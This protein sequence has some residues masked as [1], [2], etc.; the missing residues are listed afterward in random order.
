MGVQQNRAL[1]GEAVVRPLVHRLGI[2]LSR[3][4]GK[5]PVRLKPL[6]LRLGGEAEG[7]GLCS[8]E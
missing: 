2:Q 8:R 5:A 1:H 7:G 3:H 6:R 4:L